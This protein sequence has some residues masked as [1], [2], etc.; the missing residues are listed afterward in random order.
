MKYAINLQRSAIAP[1]T[2]EE[3]TDAKVDWKRMDTYT[4]NSL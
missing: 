3:V 1:A 4:I 2:I